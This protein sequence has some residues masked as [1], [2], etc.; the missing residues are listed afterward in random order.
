MER[1]GLQRVVE[2][3]DTL[4]RSYFNGHSRWGQ[5]HPVECAGVAPRT[6]QYNDAPI[7]SVRTFNDGPVI[8]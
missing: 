5:G 4:R 2:G 3:G 6:I 1:L 7:A 8:H